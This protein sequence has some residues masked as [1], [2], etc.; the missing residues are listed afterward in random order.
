MFFGKVHLGHDRIRWWRVDITDGDQPTIS[1]F[2]VTMS[3]RFTQPKMRA[4]R[5][6]APIL[7]RRPS[8]KHRLLP[9]IDLR[10]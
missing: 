1:Y 2:K 4:Y 8:Q 3:V 5:L 10:V 6:D 9:D 7:L